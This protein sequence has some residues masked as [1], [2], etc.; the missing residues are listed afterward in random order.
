MRESCRLLLLLLGVVSL[1]AFVLFGWDKLMAKLDRRRIPEATLWGAAFLGG[2]VGAC[3][4]MWVFHHK[5]RKGFFHIGLPLLAA[6]QL[7]LAAWAVLGFPG[8]PL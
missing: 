2:G 6:L 5:T 7:T 8:W 4:G 1:L 3:L